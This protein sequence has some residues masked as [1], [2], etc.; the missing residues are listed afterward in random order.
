MTPKDEAFRR[1]DPTGL[2]LHPAFRHLQTYPFVRIQE[3]KAAAE[4]R[5]RR[6]IDMGMGDPMERTPEMLRRAV[7][8]GIP[9]RMGYPPA[10][11]L[12]ELRQAVAHWIALRY[13]VQLDPERHIL[14]TNGSKEA[15]YL[16]HQAVIDPSGPRRRILIPEP[17]YPVYRIAALFA[18]GL[19]TVVPL[20][21]AGGF[22]PRWQAVPQQIWRE[23]A[24]LWLNTPHNPTG[25]AAGLD[26]LEA[27]RD[28]AR[29]H[30]V[31]VF[32][33][34]PYSEIYF[35]Q[36]PPG[37]L[38][39]GL[40]GALVFNTLS[41]RS[42]MT[43][44]RSGFIAGD[45][46]LVANLR[47]VRPSQGVATPIFVQHAAAAA[48][49]DERHVAEQRR[50]YARKRELLLPALEAAGLDVFPSQATFYLWTAV[51]QGYTSESFFVKLLEN[52]LVAT[53][54]S[55]FGEAGEGYVRLALV[56]ALDACGEAAEILAARPWQ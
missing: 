50:L 49:R 24:A 43:G 29:R 2:P 3:A 52:G 30:K 26:L 17:A 41:K 21:R 25:A 31:W 39:V 9:D 51:P 47:R 13:G 1:S 56:P 55:A 5:G 32:S 37:F 16:I 8:D 10:A 44:Y 40:E 27:T 34:E 14:P 23:T 22:L 15:L 36:P 28:T 18:G 6:M 4:S 45:P 19:P 7:I 33:D 42:A 46:G 20:D 12:P 53:P 48:W 54:G 11:G 38:Q 35:D